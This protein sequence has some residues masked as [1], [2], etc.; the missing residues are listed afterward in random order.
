MLG[1]RTEVFNFSL[2]SGSAKAIIIYSTGAKKYIRTE[3]HGTQ[4]TLHELPTQK[5][6][7]TQIPSATT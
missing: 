5:F 7:P 3:G 2:F 6:Y 4:E 1:R